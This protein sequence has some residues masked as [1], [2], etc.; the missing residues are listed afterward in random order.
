MDNTNQIKDELNILNNTLTNYIQVHDAV[1][2]Q[3]LGEELNYV[4]M[5]NQ[6]ETT[7]NS[8]QTTKKSWKII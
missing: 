7:I 6:L 3:K 8:T 5:L 2:K 4:E 1:F